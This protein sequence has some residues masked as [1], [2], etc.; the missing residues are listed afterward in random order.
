M[1]EPAVRFAVEGGPIRVTNPGFREAWDKRPSW[2][3]LVY[4]NGKR[5]TGTESGVNPEAVVHSWPIVFDATGKLRRPPAAS[6]HRDAVVAAPKMNA[7]KRR[8]RT[9]PELVAQVRELIARG[10]V[11]TAIGDALN[12]SDRRVRELAAA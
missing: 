1:F 2:H 5:G 6:K 7:P 4:G 11:L 10:L 9:S 3:G 8:R 12:I